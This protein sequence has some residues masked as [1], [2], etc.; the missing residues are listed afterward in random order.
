MLNIGIE[1]LNS[2]NRGVIPTQKV[3]V[4]FQNEVIYDE[5]NYLIKNGISNINTSM[6]DEGNYEMSNVTVT[7]L[8]RDYDLSKFYYYELPI[9]RLAVIYDVIN[10]VEIEAF[11]GKITDWKL[12]PK[13][14]ILTIT[15]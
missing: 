12:T 9:T 13:N 4:Y 5:N 11:R 7:L 6:S 3:K 1:T 15:A 10:D 8:N 14:V 2:I